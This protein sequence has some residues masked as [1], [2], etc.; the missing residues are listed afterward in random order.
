MLLFLLIHSLIYLCV[1]KCVLMYMSTHVG[2]R[3]QLVGIYSLFSSC[4]LI[5]NRQRSADIL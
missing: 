5:K 2:V 1:F 4:E 3:G